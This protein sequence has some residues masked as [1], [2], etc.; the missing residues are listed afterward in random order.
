MRIAGALLALCLSLRA[1][2]AE[3]TF[4]YRAT[5]ADPAVLVRSGPGESYYPT[6]RLLQGEVVEVYRHDPNGW[7]AIRP[8]EGEFSLISA[9]CVKLVAGDDLAEVIEHEAPVW[10]GSHLAKPD[11]HC[12]QIHLQPGERAVV[13]GVRSA[14]AGDGQEAQ[15]WYKIAPPAG[16]FR[17]IPRAALKP[18]GEEAQVTDESASE[19][20]RNSA[21]NEPPPQKSS[22]EAQD[23]AMPSTD[24]GADRPV[25]PAPATTTDMVALAK[26][27]APVPEDDAPAAVVP[28]SLEAEP[29]PVKPVMPAFVEADREIVPRPL[30]TEGQQAV[31]AS[32]ESEVTSL[33]PEF[34]AEAAAIQLDVTLAVAKDLNLWRLG[35]L[36]DRVE[37]L[38]AAAT[39]A[40]ERQ[41]AQA[42]DQ[43]LTGFENLYERY[44]RL[45]TGE[46]V[47]A[48]ASP[49]PLPQRRRPNAPPSS[50]AGQDVAAGVLTPLA[51]NGRTPP[52]ALLDREG[53]ITAYVTP[54][55]DA[56]LTPYLG[57]HVQVQG[58][59]AAQND[60]GP[61][62]LVSARAAS[63][64]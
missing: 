31:P 34:A 62:H 35:P 4:P 22:P 18:V 41:E 55:A 9:D 49:A 54:A 46:G 13:L 17:W 44:R 14:P 3:E 1:V 20:T 40:A 47:A 53:R 64:R 38:K 5:V 30:T 23:N 7:C 57:R 59:R 56:N 27:E 52:L 25:L 28:A 21:P 58:Q 60:A 29:A 37:K 51:A 12:W 16:E 26:Y 8:P 15:L 10:V 43:S 61:V 2:G 11:P 45:A 63:V 39:T 32:F 33:S 42:L 6:S 48:T 24:D 19:Q 50:R 36:R